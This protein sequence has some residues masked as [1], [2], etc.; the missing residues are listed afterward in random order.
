VDDEIDLRKY[1][2]VLIR[3][4]KLIVGLGVATALAAGLVSALLPPVYE[5][6]A[7]VVV[8][9]PRY[10]LRL[11]STSPT[12]STQLPLK[13]YPELAL[14]DN[15]LLETFNQLQ[16]ELPKEL[17]DLSSFRAGLKAAPSADPTLLSL[18]VR[19]KDPEQAAR[20]VNVWAQVFAARAGQ[21]YG[22]DEANLSNYQEQLKTAEDRLDAAEE[23]LAAFQASNQ[24]AVLQAQLDTKQSA[25]TDYLRSLHSFELL[26]QDARDFLIRLEALDPNA[27][28]SLSDDLSML[29][30]SSRLFG[31]LGSSLQL[32][33]PSGQSLSGKTVSE[34]KA[35]VRELITTVQK[36]VEVAKTKSAALE[37]EIL[38]LQG[39]LAQ[40]RTQDTRL[41]RERDIASSQYT[42]LQS[43]YTE[44]QIA[45]QEFANIVQVASEAAVP[46]ESANIGLLWSTLLGG[47]LGTLV[48]VL[49]VFV[50][51]WWREAEADLRTIPADGRALPS[52]A[53]EAQRLKEPAP[54]HSAD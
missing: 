31:G 7:L 37:P 16:P 49:F 32:Q 6:E 12:G 44:A 33:V 20:I 18:T 51:D 42:V 30:L 24:E 3:Q 28:A 43:R 10:A 52:I 17:G 45:A 4:W 14:S 53:E 15:V 1:I 34:Q 39:K 47:A 35:F 48:G 38:D 46:D 29:S 54:A 25:M 19:D 21:L 11:A 22:Q 40:V 50:W 13:A 23:A 26:A 36:Q 27:P 41:I 8:A 5:A 9:L 2:R